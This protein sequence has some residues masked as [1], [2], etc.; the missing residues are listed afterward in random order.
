MTFFKWLCSLILIFLFVGIILKVG[1]IFINILLLI[2]AFIFM[3]D[4]LFIKR[5]G[6]K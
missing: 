5:K 6:F 1:A 3:I 4:I 2:C